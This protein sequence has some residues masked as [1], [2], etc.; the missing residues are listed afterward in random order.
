MG[1]AQAR[2][3]YDMFCKIE[4]W[5]EVGYNLMVTWTQLTSCFGNILRVESLN[6]FTNLNSDLPEQ[7]TNVYVHVNQCINVMYMCLYMYTVYMYMYVQCVSVL[8]TF[9]YMYDM[10]FVQIYMYYDTSFSRLCIKIPVIYYSLVKLLIL[11]MCL[12]I[13]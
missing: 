5:K 9:M 8:Y 6:D 10:Y 11:V 7:S 2:P 12:K 1:L 13:I 3:N 4:Y